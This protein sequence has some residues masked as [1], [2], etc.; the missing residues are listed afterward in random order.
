LQGG[1]KR[2][3]G[4]TLG[5]IFISFVGAGVLGLPYAFSRSGLL[6]G[7]LVML[8]VSILAYICI[9]LLVDCKKTLEPHGAVRSARLLNVQ[10]IV[11]FQKTLVFLRI[12][13]T[14][15]IDICFQRILH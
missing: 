13:D 5:N 7:A 8:V 3:V 10:N 9:L 2:G 15:N 14:T 6:L 11:L 4:K 1:D 12:S